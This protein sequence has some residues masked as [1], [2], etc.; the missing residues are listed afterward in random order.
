MKKKLINDF[1]SIKMMLWAKDL[2]PINRSITG[3]GVRKT[4]S[5]IKQNANKNFQIKKILSNKKVYDWKIPKEWNLKKASIQHENG[6]KVCDF[7]DN[8]L[9]ILGYSKKI[10]KVL[11]YN[12]LKKNIYYLKEKPNSLPY[13]TSYYKKKWGFSL[14][15]SQF[16]KLNKNSS[17]KVVIDS[18]HFNGKMNYTE[19]LI[20]GKSKKEILIVSYICHPSMANNELSG[21]LIVMALSKI[22]KPQ[23]YS[24]RLLLIPETIGA[25]AYINKNIKNLQNNL[26]AGFNLSCVGD[27]GPFTLI[28]SKE[29]NNYADK[30]AQR[31]LKKTK[32][33]KILSFLKRGSNERQFGCQNLNFPFVTICRTRFE[34]Y[35]EYHTSDDNLGII[36]ETNL[37]KTLKQILLMIQEIQKNK[38]FEKTMK[39]EPFFTKYN[40]VRS[41][42]G[43][44]NSSETDLYNL[45]AYVD[46]N[47]D[48]YEL[49]KILNR[50]KKYI[51][52]N[53]KIL[54]KNKIIKEVL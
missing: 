26:I 33:F 40:L 16:K 51:N 7:K 22:L 41:T 3:E 29:S 35:K 48:E 50:P 10:N 12:L 19:L 17:F 49:S 6:K 18:K 54:V 9:H 32:N 37:K 28:S 2:F 43:K 46:R 23:K 53:L 21:P 42:R 5:Y 4:I 39:C 45:S 25:I 8:N 20:K 15:Y 52:Y 44:Y 14:T 34:D 30:I 47:Y 31:V 1:K 36:S 11:K 38:I 13:R 24:V 27:K